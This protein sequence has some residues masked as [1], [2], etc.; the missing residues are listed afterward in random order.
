VSQIDIFLSYPSKERPMALT[1][2]EELRSRG[3]QTWIDVEN[4]R[5]GKLWQDEVEKV[6]CTT[7]ATAVLVGSEGLGPWEVPEVRACLTQLVKRQTPVIPVLL[8]GAERRPEL[9][10]FLAE[11]TWVDMSAGI[12]DQGIDQIIWG[13]TG[14]RPDSFSEDTI[15]CRV[16]GRPV[17]FSDMDWKQVCPD[18]LPRKSRFLLLRRVQFSFVFLLL[19]SIGGFY[20]PFVYGRP[21]LQSV[22]LTAYTAWALF[23]GL[24]IAWNWQRRQPPNSLGCLALPSMFFWMFG[25]FLYSVLGGGL[26]SCAAFCWDQ[27]KKGRNQLRASDLRGRFG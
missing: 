1:L 15:T 3:L 7:Q 26:Y 16:C 24:P 10:A 5:P 14:K 9:P 8:P 21:D 6:I 20:N 4:L 27:K 22:I 23:W 18:C 12:T 2:A 13:A 19:G 25:A 11:I 17:S